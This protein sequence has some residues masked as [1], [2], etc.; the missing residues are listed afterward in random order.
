MISDDVQEVFSRGFDT[1]RKQD[2]ISDCLP[3]LKEKKPPVLIVMDE[4]GQYK[5]VIAH[6][7]VVR[8]TLNLSTT[9][10]ETLMRP[11]PKV[12]LHDS[13]SRAAKLMIGSES[14]Q[15]PVYSGEKLVGVIT[16]E[17]V[18]HGAVL[19]QWGKNKVSEVMT[20]NPYV[21]SE[22]ESVGSAL[23]IL[24]REGISHLPVIKD[25]R[26]TGMLSIRDI[27][28]KVLKPRKR[29]EL[30]ERSGEKGKVLSISVKG[31]MSEPV[32]TISPES[33]LQEAED[34]MHEFDISSLVVTKNE[35]PVGIITK[36]D[37]LEPIARMEAPQRKITIQFSLAKVDL[38]ERQRKF[39][40]E[41]FKTL[42]QKYEETLKPGTLF[43][44]MKTHGTNYKGDQLIHCR[45]QL[46]T[47]DK[48]FYSSSE[49]WGTE[50]PF[51]R[52][53]D[54]LDKQILRSKELEHR[55][56]FVNKY[57]ERIGFPLSGV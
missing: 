29:Q 39:M 57:L 41:D 3:L 22:E 42:V 8:S 24:R 13:L 2:K 5:G 40:V 43:V 44:Y 25:G 17:D 55:P 21:V 26:V 15:L 51:F 27:I 18:I 56:E 35:K 52:A 19:G 48:S 50:Q 20:Q 9:K 10:V 6:R 23:S 53:L 46:R 32:I 7:G 31:I 14:M 1:V 16:H 30:G 4:D 33:T 11:A 12:K 28:D 37:F 36:R 38:D 45:L 54:R 47:Q 34:K 49:G